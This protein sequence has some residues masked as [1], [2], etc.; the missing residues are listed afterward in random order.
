MSKVYPES[1]YVKTMMHIVEMVENRQ[2]DE[3]SMPK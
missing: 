3:Q 1:E 2:S